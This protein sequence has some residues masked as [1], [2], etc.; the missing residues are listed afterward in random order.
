MSERSE[1]IDVPAVPVIQRKLS[2]PPP[3]EQL[4]A[5]PRLDAL[6][7]QLIESHPVVL[8]CATAGAGKTTAVSEAVKDI[9]ASVAWLALDETDNAPGRL[10]TYLEASLEVHVPQIE[11]VATR[12]LAAG[13]PHVEAAGLLAEAVG[14]ARVALVLDDLQRLGENRD[15]WAVIEAL[16]RYAPSRLTVVLLSRRDLPARACEL[17]ATGQT[18]GIGEKELAFTLEE[19]ADAL[20]QRAAEDMDAAAAI[21]ATGGW[22]TGVLF[23]AWRS[24]GHVAGVG[25]EAD[26]LRGYLS[27]HILERLEPADRE[28]LI[29][30]SL[31]DVVTAAHAD[32]LGLVG[33]GDRLTSIRAAH[34]PV[35][36]D[37]ASGAMRCHPRFREYLLDLLA[38]RGPEEVN[39]LR[40]AHARVLARLGENEEATEE[41]LRAGAPEGAV[42]TAERAIFDVI[43]RLDF[44]IA[45]RWIEALAGTTS[46][47]ATVLTIA[48]LMSAIAQDD[49]RRGERIADQLAALGER[50]RLA[51]ASSRAA[52]LMGWC[53]L[54]VGR[55][56]EVDAIVERA[57]PSPEID[58]IRYARWLVA[59]S[60]D[61]SE[62]V[63]P[64]GTGGPLDVLAF[65]ASYYLGRLRELAEPKGSRWMEALSAPYRIGA[66]RALGRT[67]EALELYEEHKRG[68]DLGI[69]FEATIAPEILIDSGRREDARAAVALGRERA[70][71]SGSLGLQAVNRVLEAKLALRL[72]RDPTRARELL[73]QLERDT[74]VRRFRHTSDQLDMWYGLALL[75]LSE[76]EPATGRLRRAVAGMVA[77][78]RKLELPTAAVYL[79]EAE[80]RMGEEEAAD[81][82][83]DLALSAAREQGSN[84]LLLQA[85]GDFPAVASRRIDAEPDVDS[86]WHDVA[87]ALT[88]QAVGTPVAMTSVRLEDFGR[89]RILVDGDEA[90]PGLAKSLELLALLCMRRGQRIDREALLDALFDGRSD[91]SARAY[92]RQ[93]VHRLRGILPAGTLVAENDTVGLVDGAAVTSDSARFESA[94]TEAARLQ[95]EQRLHAT[96]DALDEYSEAPFLAEVNSRWAEDRRR[97]LAERATE[98]RDEAAELAFSIGRLKEARR[99]SDAALHADPYR[100]A[101]WRLRMR[102]ANAL[103]DENGVIAAFQ[104]CEGALAELGTTPADSTRRLL[105]TLRR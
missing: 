67:N 4:V 40:K 37:S 44:A 20:K 15:A 43:E 53:Y 89:P 41:F 71:A 30:T 2:P 64:A 104:A 48:E 35:S 87:R 49:Y 31:L 99:L 101:T 85:L 16:V 21:D 45:D 58:A 105:D 77:G 24:S 59:D 19:A 39:G 73:D 32:A 51:V 26:P 86:P 83:A 94:L 56:D 6:L 82:A 46:T 47:G 52:A 81:A 69:T 17:L 13:I 78:G 22:V 28:F 92:L 36:W 11:K 75:Q 10:V 57:H 76:D 72:E 18:P 61:G 63:L 68:R 91:A 5:R 54:H 34:L 84:H 23:E 8:V 98:A 79:A 62:P 25:G 42:E 93:A 103:G 55:L 60:P 88:A 12:A 7:K 80:W 90:R 70:R 65:V 27:A 74:A 29:Q 38:R 97:D 14:D 33:A 50:D 9:G 102:I 3:S 1:I 96:L 95:G 100:E 66:L